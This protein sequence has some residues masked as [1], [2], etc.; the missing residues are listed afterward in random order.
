MI[1]LAASPRP[2]E[3]RCWITEVVPIFQGAAFFESTAFFRVRR[4]LP[5]LR[6]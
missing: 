5:T 6:P 4:F 3:A 2:I 1:F